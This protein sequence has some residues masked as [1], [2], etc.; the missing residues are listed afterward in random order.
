MQDKPRC[1]YR[2]VAI[3]RAIRW[4]FIRVF[5]AR[6][7]TNARRVPREMEQACPIRIQRRYARTTARRSTGLASTTD[8]TP[9]KS[10][11]INGMAARE[12]GRIGAV[13]Q[14]HRFQ[15]SAALEPTL[16]RYVQLQS[17]APPIS[18]GKQN[19][20]ADDAGPAQTQAGIVPETNHITF[21]E[22]T[23]SRYSDGCTALI[24][25]RV[26]SHWVARLTPHSKDVQLLHPRFLHPAY[27]CIKSPLCRF[28]AFSWDTAYMKITCKPCTTPF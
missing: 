15:S 18:P 3:D 22:G 4:R 28:R 23:Y 12:G 7:P 17:A 21:R 20:I 6:T 19:A 16:H 14:S 9:S 5:N 11:R 1:R 13:L 2:F 24:S 10:P 8:F 25:T 26:S 27:P